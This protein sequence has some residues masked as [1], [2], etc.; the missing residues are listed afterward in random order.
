M[1]YDF[2]SVCKNN[3][4]DIPKKYSKNIDILIIITNDEVY[5]KLNDVAKKVLNESANTII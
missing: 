4:Y 3:A 1:I 2:L 5:K